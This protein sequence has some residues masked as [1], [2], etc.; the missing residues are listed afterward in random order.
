M[1]NK[2][3]P[4]PLIGEGTAEVESFASYI[5]RSA[6]SHGVNVGV[7]IR[8]VHS[9]A[10]SDPQ[11]PGRCDWNAPKYIRPEELVSSN[12][13]TWNLVNTMSHFSKQS[14]APGILW[15]LS[16][17]VGRSNGEICDGF[18]WCPECLAE[19]E[20]IGGAAYFKLIWHL[21]DIDCCPIH[22]TPLVGECPK[23]GCD[24]TTYIKQSPL[25]F[26][27]SCGANLAKRGKKLKL[28]DIKHSWEI[29]G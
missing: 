12:E 29:S 9:E 28:S 22:R 24:Q 1:S 19:N 13:L 6:K 21:K 14:L 5:H 26:C 3:F 7:L 25:N 15:F 17:I 2:L 11:L 27:Q 10:N 18:R 23:C 16:S 4:I 20:A 8:H